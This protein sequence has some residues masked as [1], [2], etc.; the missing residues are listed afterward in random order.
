[1]LKN[2]IK[3]DNIRMNVTETDANGL[4]NADTI[5]EFTQDGSMVTAKYAGGGIQTGFLVGVLNGNS[6]TFRYAQLQT[7]GKL[8]G[9]QSVCEVSKTEDGRI[10]L[11]E[12][13]QWESRPGTGINVFEEIR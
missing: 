5:F 1:M 8:D 6:L 13:F 11:V 2:S 10:R 12:H 9:G 3:L 4:V 7:D